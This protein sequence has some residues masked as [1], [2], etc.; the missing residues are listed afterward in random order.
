MCHRNVMPAGRQRSR[1]IDLLLAAT[2]P[3]RDRE[4]DR[5]AA[6]RRAWREEHVAD[7]VFSKIKNARPGADG[8]L[9]HPCGDGEIIQRAHD[10]R[11]QTDVAA[12]A[13]Q[14]RSTAV[15]AGVPVRAAE[16]RASP[17]VASGI[18]CGGSGILVERQIRHRRRRGPGENFLTVG[19]LTDGIHR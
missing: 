9:I 6:A 18:N 2:G 8:I 7:G 1:A 4:T 11:G 15:V 14:V 12:R 3:D 16:Q 10:A 5:P 17:A 13:V 19:A